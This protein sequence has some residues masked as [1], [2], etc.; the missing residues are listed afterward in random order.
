LIEDAAIG[1]V[2]FLRLG[3]ATSYFFDRE[4]FYFRKE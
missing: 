4:Q 2:R 3:P 1:K